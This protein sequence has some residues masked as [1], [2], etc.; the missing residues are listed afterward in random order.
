MKE[1]EAKEL[2]GGVLRVD[3]ETLAQLWTNIKTKFTAHGRPVSRVTIILSLIHEGVIFIFDISH[4]GLSVF[5][6]LCF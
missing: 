6:P 5:E 1:E 4:F 2:L 3:K